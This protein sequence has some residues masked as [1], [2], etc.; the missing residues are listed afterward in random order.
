MWLSKINALQGRYLTGEWTYMLDGVEMRIPA[1]IAPHRWMVTN[2]LVD[3]S[4][5]P[6][7][8]KLHVGGGAAGIVR[9]SLR[10]TEK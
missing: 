10:F 4:A 1:N 2:R 5:D 7:T 3:T 6:R 9:L 8:W